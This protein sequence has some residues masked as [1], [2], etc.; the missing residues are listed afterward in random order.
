M[1]NRGISRRD[2]MR[3]TAGATLAGGSLI[4]DPGPLASASARPVAPSDTIRFGIIGVGMQGSGLL[5]TSIRLP[6]VECVAACDLYD[7]RQE[8]AKEIVGKPIPVTR[9]YHELLD[10]KEIDCLI[11]AV[12]D[13]W[14]KQVVVDACSAGKDIYCEK[15]MTHHVPE[16]FEIIAAEKANNRIVQIGSQR[17]SSI[18]YAK[19]KELYEQGAIGELCLVEA[20]MGRNDPCGAWQYTVPPDLSP[21]TVDWETWLGTAPK[22]PFDP[23]RWTRWRC[24]QDYGEGIPGDLYVHLLTGIHYATGITA[25]PARALAAG[26]LFR[27]KDGRDV[28]DVLTTLYE[29]PKFRATLRVTLNTETPEFTRLMGDRGTIEIHDET[30]TFT[31]QDGLDHEPCT[32]G[33]P[34]QMKADYAEHWFGEH[35]PKPQTQSPVES[36]TFSGPPGYDEDRE[37][38]W[39]YFQSVRTRRP[40]VEDG[41]F[42]NNTAIA[43]HMANASYFAKSVAAWD[44]AGMKIKT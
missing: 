1:N 15:P 20:A 25:P 16:G 21:S 18:I 8:L 24:F 13:H 5:G 4:V 7:G 2:F 33:W 12:P 31:P 27:W 22:L 26:G 29:Y 6:G 34:R 37:H 35:E 36:T 19:A 41:T 9:R 32:P 23:L 39:N 30:V 40:S 3:R 42:G 11:A 44:A 17:R 28:P 10:N 38:L 14:H 43:C